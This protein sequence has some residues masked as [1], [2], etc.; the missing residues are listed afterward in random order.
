M[1]KRLLLSFL[2]IGLLPLL[3]IL[4][5]SDSVSRAALE[6]SI[7]DHL[8]TIMEARDEAIT[9]Y[10]DDRKR[11]IGILATDQKVLQFLQSVNDA[12][13]SAGSVN[14]LDG[15]FQNIVDTYGFYDLFLFDSNGTILYSLQRKADFGTNVLTGPL[16]ESNLA[17][18]FKNG[19]KSYHVT[20]YQ[21]YEPSD[22]NA[23]FLTSPVTEQGGKVLGV[24][25]VQM[26]DTGLSALMNRTTG[27]G[28]TGQSYLVGQ[29]RLLRSNLRFYEDK[30]MNVLQINTEAVKDALAG[31]QGYQQIENADGEEVLTAYAPV[32]TAGMD[33][34]IVTEMEVEEA[35]ASIDSLFLNHIA[36]LLVVSLLIILVAF[37]IAA[38]MSRPILMVKTELQQLA[39][40]GG[41]LTRQIDI[42]RSDEIG[43]LGKSLNAFIGNIREIV[44]G[45]KESSEHIA[46]SSEQLAASAEETEQVSNQVA[47]SI[48]EISQGA[49]V[50]AELAAV[51]SQKVL[52]AAEEALE[53]KRRI[54][55]MLE[56]TQNSRHFAKQ[57]REAMKH[58]ISE[59]TS[60]S[61]D[62]QKA[63]S[64]TEALGK[65]SEE[66]GNISSI[67]SEISDQTNLLS[68]NASIEAA[69]A[70]EHGRGFA[71]VA[72]EVKKLAEQS[73][74]NSTKINEVINQI[75]KEMKDLAEFM[76][77]SSSSVSSEVH[78][79]QD[80][81]KA[82]DV[83]VDAITETE[84]NA[85]SIE[86]FFTDLAETIHHVS[87]SVEEVAG[88]TEQ[89]AASSEQVAASAQE[90]SATMT[91]VT[92][93]LEN[94]AN[95]SES[96]K[97]DVKKFTV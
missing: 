74:E 16:K 42:R 52:S 5:F 10:Y 69:R 45:V 38:R 49:T 4:Y 2:L 48:E 6:E 31:N 80:S 73:S 76:N 15:Y 29:D 70:G 68:L 82:L 55:K 85:K 51:I 72:N 64:S 50:Q 56:Q 1:R 43:Q 78:K 77:H 71:V 25:G 65:R 46:A 81:N 22:Q 24:I 47:A 61:T 79:I 97:E 18:A 13:V 44:S 19:L 60:V 11:N 9:D 86:M 21:Y 67:I 36:A 12:D 28:E 93:S 17:E 14:G 83:I 54:E 63:A 89:T 37:F 8:V 62:V 39:A 3:T 87:A 20:D 75:Q 40:S 57:S 35:Y 59:L 7:E 27:L 84:R 92:S 66:I 53:G 26:A 33:W 34:A 90:Q 91:Q 95:I 23:A 32:S 58:A 30:T 94:L 96:L 41:D 88:I